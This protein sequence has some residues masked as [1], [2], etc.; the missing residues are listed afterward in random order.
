MRTFYT[1]ASEN[2]LIISRDRV[3]P[4]RLYKGPVRITEASCEIFNRPVKTP[5]SCDPIPL[6]SKTPVTKGKSLGTYSVLKFAYAILD[7]SKKRRYSINNP[8]EVLKEGK[9]TTIAPIILFANT[10]IL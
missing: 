3:D 8:V 7:N 5:S 1:I 10:N 4:K 6:Y 9:Y 2:R